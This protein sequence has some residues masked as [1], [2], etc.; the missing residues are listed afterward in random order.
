[1]K[2]QSGDKAEAPLSNHLTNF[3]A[4]DEQYEVVEFFPHVGR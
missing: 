4:N 1:M 2:C 3:G